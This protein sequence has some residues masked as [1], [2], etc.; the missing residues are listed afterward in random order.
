MEIAYNIAAGIWICTGAFAADADQVAVVPPEG[1][2]LLLEVVADGPV[3]NFLWLFD[4][5]QRVPPRQQ[6]LGAERGSMQLLIRW[7][8]ADRSAVVGD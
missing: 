6:P 7:R 5:G 1:S 4:T 8:C 2:V 3:A